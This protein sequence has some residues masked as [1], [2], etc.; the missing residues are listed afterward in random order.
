MQRGG[1][2]TGLPTKTEQSDLFMAL[3]GRHG[4][5]PMP[6]I[7]ARQPERLLLR[8][9]RGLPIAVK[10]MTP[11]MLLTDGY[12]GYG[13]EP[14]RIPEEGELKPFLVKYQTT[15]NYNGLHAVPARR[16][17]HPPLGH[18]G[19]AR[20]RAPHRRPREGLDVRHGLATTA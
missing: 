3:F 8:D 5:A 14:F 4:E 6:V 7:A 16:E 2:S 10:Y 13:S 12:L 20:P 9:H 11:V 17:A 1:P 19:H 18:P 15:P